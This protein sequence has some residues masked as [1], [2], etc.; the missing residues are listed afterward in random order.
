[1]LSGLD[2][3]NHDGIGTGDYAKDFVIVK[4]TEGAGYTD[5]VCD[6]HFQRAKAQGK[7]L[8]FYHFARPDLGN[9]PEQE[10]DY[11]IQ[12]T[13]GYFRQAI[14]VLDWE[15]NVWQVEWAK[16]WLDRVYEKTGIRPMIYMSASVVNDYDWCGVSP[17][18]GLWI[19]GYPAKYDIKNP[20]EPTPDD[21]PYAI[22][23]WAFW[24]IWQYTSCK[25][26]LDKDI[27]C[28][29]SVA[30]S[31]YAGYYKESSKPVE[32]P[33]EEPKP[34][35][36][37]VEPEPTPEPKEEESVEKPEPEPTPEPAEPEQPVK[38]ENIFERVIMVI[39][40]FIK[41]LFKKGE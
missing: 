13:Q 14:P 22:G 36:V 29:D 11:F 3:S 40:K 16:R 18:Y 34:E 17:Y 41:K 10:A 26:S 6:S 35:P 39:I 23:S 15:V 30:W 5:K 19:A 4:A 25:N 2:I 8:G 27:A 38:M 7:L 20:P 33:K 12:E 37:V 24:C 31:K 1:M 21:M 28:I 9:T 32:K